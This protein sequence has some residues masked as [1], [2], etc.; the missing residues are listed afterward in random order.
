[1]MRKS[2]LWIA[3]TCCLLLAAGCG[4]GGNG[5]PDGAATLRKVS[6]PD[7]GLWVYDP[8]VTF[9]WALENAGISSREENVNY[10][11]RFDGIGEWVDGKTATSID[12]TMD[13]AGDHT[14]EVYATQGLSLVSNTLVW[15][16]VYQEEDPSLRP[17]VLFV[18]T[19]GPIINV[20][21]FHFEWIGQSLTSVIVGYEVNLEGI[22]GDGYKW[23]SC[24]MATTYTQ[25]HLS[26]GEH[27]FAVRTWDQAGRV[28]LPA[29]YKFEY[30][31]AYT[32][33]PKEEE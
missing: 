14:F 18:T 4:G 19:P 27:T 15:S 20:D 3:L 6:G 21:H 16:F 8:V 17:Y 31:P 23:V 9:S 12:W 28:S 33:N 11:Y 30:D 7:D 5:V 10:Y 1:M 26:V 2:M 24:G 25:T 22:D 29:E 13:K 32:V